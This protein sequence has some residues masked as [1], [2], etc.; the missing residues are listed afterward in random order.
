MK[1][2]FLGL[3]GA[4]KGTQAK[5]LTANRDVEHVSTGDLLRAEV[6]SGSKLGKSAAQ[7]MNR[8]ELVP[9]DLVIAMVVK[10]ISGMENYLLD[11]FPRTL[12]QA[13]ALH[14]ATEGNGVDR[15]FDF[16]L[17]EEEVVKRL[18]GRR[19]CRDCSAMFHVGFMPPKSEG[20]CDNCGGALM[21]RDD[22]HPDT[23]RNRTRIAREQAGPLLSFYSDKGL[24]TRI[25]A[26][27]PADVVQAEI[28]SYLSD[29]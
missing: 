26:A 16:D 5:K 17:E 20:V 1:W 19:V 2:V 15:V 13:V 28:L 12:E 21:R 25:D 29:S 4:G 3:P 24:L 18:G 27:R 7:Y 14:E 23:I 9:D 10:Y 6:K 8:G 11:G 22:D